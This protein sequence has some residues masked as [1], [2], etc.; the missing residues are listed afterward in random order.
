MPDARKWWS[1]TRV[2]RGGEEQD[3]FGLYD[4]CQPCLRPLL[5]RRKCR[6]GVGITFLR[7]GIAR[8]TGPRGAISK[9]TAVNLSCL[10]TLSDFLSLFLSFPSPF[11]SHDS[12]NMS[13]DS[14]MSSLTAIIMPRWT[15]CLDISS[16]NKIC[17]LR[18]MISY[19]FI[20][21]LDWEKKIKLMGRRRR[22]IKLISVTIPRLFLTAGFTRLYYKGF[23]DTIF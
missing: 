17:I 7:R 4:G 13:S 18:R 10:T 15:L 2:P 21:D 12:G 1:R 8:R 22:K 5:R 16:E 19:H 3:A 20:S 14:Y 11:L 23:Y 6:R 9:E